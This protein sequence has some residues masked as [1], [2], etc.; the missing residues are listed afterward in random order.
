[1]TAFACDMTAMNSEQRAC[2]WDLLASLHKNRFAL[3]E[4]PNGYAMRFAYDEGLVTELIEFVTLERLCCLFLTL[5]VELESS[6]GPMRLRLTGADGVKPFLVAELGCRGLEADPLSHPT[7][8][9][10]RTVQTY[11]YTSTQARQPSI[12]RV[13]KGVFPCPRNRVLERR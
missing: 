4:L 11:G 10:G 1:M 13:E 7:H 5:A 6:G 12:S 2:Y 3:E 9:S 8:Q